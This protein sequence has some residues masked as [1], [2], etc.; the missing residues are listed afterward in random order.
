MRSVNTE[1]LL[2]LHD[3]ICSRLYYQNDTVI[4]EMENMDIYAVHPDNPYEEAHQ[5]LGGR[6]VL[7]HPVVG[8]LCP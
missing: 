6:I 4:F 3:C 1:H 8:K 7:K 2:S 5:A